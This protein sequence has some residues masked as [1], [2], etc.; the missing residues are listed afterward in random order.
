MTCSCTRHLE[1]MTTAALH[2]HDCWE[3]IYTLSGKVTET[4]G[5]HQQYPHAGDVSVIP[6]GIPHSRRAQTTFTDMYI[7]IP[8]A[9]LAGISMVSDPDGC[10][11]TLMNLI[12]RLLLEKEPG[13]LPLVESLCESVFRCI[14]R[15]A[16]LKNENPQ[17]SRLKN[18]LYEHI[19]D[20][21]FDLSACLSDCG[22]SENHMRSRF[23][24]E[25]GMPP[26]QYLTHLRIRQA[27]NLLLQ[28]DFVSVS[29]VSAECGFTD[30]LYFS[31]CFK[32]HTGLSPLAYRSANLPF[33][34][35]QRPLQGD[36]YIL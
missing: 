3:I 19:G 6:P 33:K 10:I 34:K 16:R 1:P 28:T 27:E 17:V 15:N 36:K 25:T 12:H 9:D 26:L 2:R 14:R 32:K 30:P 18:I 23:K 35:S 5:V 4:R 11:L 8:T 21:G 29:R 13:S 31:T 7:Q 20:A 22:Y 24:E